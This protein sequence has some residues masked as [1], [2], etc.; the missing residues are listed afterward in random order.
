MTGGTGA[1][2]D[3]DAA[4]LAAH[5]AGDEPALVALYRAAAETCEQDGAPDAAGFFLT[6]AYVIALHCG[7]T[8]ARDLLARLVAQGRESAP[9]PGLAELGIEAP[10]ERAAP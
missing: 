9:V 10:A 6:Q 4:L 7:E 8:S 3:L 5:A 2:V 1:G